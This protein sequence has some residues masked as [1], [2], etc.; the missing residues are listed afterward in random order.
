MADLGWRAKAL[1]AAAFVALFGV[2]I[3]LPDLLGD[4][5]SAGEDA[6]PNFELRLVPDLGPGWTVRGHDIV[7]WPDE[8]I[9]LFGFSFYGRGSAD[10]PFAD[11]DLAISIDRTPVGRRGSYT[12]PDTVEVRGVEGFVRQPEDTAAMQVGWD[13]VSGVAVSLISTSRTIEE[14]VRIADELDLDSLAPLG[15]EFEGLT[16]L[17]GNLPLT[18]GLW[19]VSA[20][21]ADDDGVSLQVDVGGAWF[22]TIFHLGPDAQPVD[23]RGT[24]GLRS[25]FVDH[26]RLSW[27]EDGLALTL[28]APFDMDPVAIAEGLR[29]VD[30]ETWAELSADR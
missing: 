28:V 18:S 17:N 1:I 15:A 4:D 25:D 3:A 9:D 21:E 19:S 27:R 6:E 23:V 24:V 7:P 11:D 26:R 22:G 30:A 14:L 8:V 20:R 16:L 10:T 12:G 13:D 29:E 2:G 5:D